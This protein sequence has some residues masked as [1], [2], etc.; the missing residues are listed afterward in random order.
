MWQMNLVT[1]WPSLS[2]VQKKRF[3]DNAV[4]SKRVVCYT[5]EADIPVYDA[6]VFRGKIQLCRSAGLNC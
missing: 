3:P 6:L 1:F 5:R 2:P 4:L